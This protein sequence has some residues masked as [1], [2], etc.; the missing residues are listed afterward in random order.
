MEAFIM[1]YIIIIKTIF[2]ATITY[3]FFVYKQNSMLCN[4]HPK[5]IIAKQLD[6]VL[7]DESCNELI[8]QITVLYKALKQAIDQEYANT[9][10]IQVLK[11]KLIRHAMTIFSIKEIMQ[12]NNTKD[13]LVK[14]LIALCA[15]TSGFVDD[16]LQ[17]NPK[18]QSC[19]KEARSILESFKKSL[20]DL[21]PQTT[22]HIKPD[23]KC[24]D[25]HYATIAQ[26][27][28]KM[29][30]SEM[31]TNNR[32]AQELHNVDQKLHPYGE[33][34]EFHTKKALEKYLSMDDVTK[35]I[36]L[37]QSPCYTKLEKELPMVIEIATQ[38]ISSGVKSQTET[39]L[40]N[41]WN[42]TKNSIFALINKLKN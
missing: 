24:I 30:F 9:N 17:L 32:I 6:V 1:K 25:T 7:Q 42:Q 10:Q 12:I 29:I 5:E 4:A 38:N 37:M 27:L 21:I 35:L 31:P 33:L 2:I 18:T 39:L 16:V 14:M 3:C 20:E 23:K 26:N 15:G 11:N 34:F 28:K 41:G 8:S 13:A 19:K 22:T 40:T 36:N